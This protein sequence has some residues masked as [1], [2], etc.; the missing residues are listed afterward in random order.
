MRESL[1]LPKSG[2]IALYVSGD[3]CESKI[4]QVKLQTFSSSHG[5]QGRVR[6]MRTLYPK[7]TKNLNY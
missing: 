7:N 4:Y 5:K 3:A 1:N 2:F 6:N